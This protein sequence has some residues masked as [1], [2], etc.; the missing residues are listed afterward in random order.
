MRL[1][2]CE[3]ACKSAHAHARVRVRGC[4]WPSEG[5]NVSA[6]VQVHVRG[7]EGASG[8]DN[9]ITSSYENCAV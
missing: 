4:E 6:R 8:R 3:R 2:G 5:A 7:C 1:R 9:T